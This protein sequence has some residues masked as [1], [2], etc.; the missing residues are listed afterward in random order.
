VAAGRRQRAA[1]PRPTPNGD[2]WADPNPDAIAALPAHRRPVGR[3]LAR[4]G[5]RPKSRATFAAQLNQVSR[6]LQ[7]AAG[8]EPG[9]EV[10]RDDYPW[11]QLDAD[12]ADR[13]RQLIH[14]RYRNVGT[15]NLYLSALRE[16]LRE[17]FRAELM[18]ARRFETL[19]TA[20][21]TKAVGRTGRGRRLS[22]EEIAAL[23][24]ACLADP[25]P[26]RAARDAAV[27]A[28]FATTGIRSSD[29]V[30][31]DL[32]D[33]DDE[34]RSLYLACTKNGH[35]HTVY[36]PAVAAEY[37]DRWSSV[38]GA[39]PGPLFTKVVG[40]PLQ[41]MA[42]ST[43][44]TLLRVRAG[45]AHV[46]PFGSHDFR[47]TVATILLRTHDISIVS[48]ILG[49]RDVASTGVYDLS[50]AEDCRAAVETLPI[51]DPAS[52]PVTPPEDSPEPGHD[53]HQ[54]ERGA[55]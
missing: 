17:R 10:V 42:Y 48:R 18:S 44:A 36:L 29:L 40:P 43:V 45:Q 9:Q 15:R 54:N 30:D 2:D 28:V 7:Q 52:N 11:H 13:Y 1:L 5:G 6:L 50:D 16:V 47:R 49:H 4:R 3:V 23:L 21:P 26:R 31:L 20:L 32:G 41:P 37:L 22:G 33:W 51:P 25:Q 46:K 8:I 24:G 39:T 53:D 14:A 19:T 55:A 38:R 34:Q 35:P 27:I 12:L